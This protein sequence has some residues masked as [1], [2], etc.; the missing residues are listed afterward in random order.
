M[1]GGGGAPEVSLACRFDRALTAL[2]RRLA[3]AAARSGTGLTPVQLF[4]LRSLREP[5][6]VSVTS[7]AMSLGVGPSAVTLLLNR[8]EQMGLIA[9]RRDP[10]DRR[11]VRIRLTRPGRS[12]LARA[13]RRRTRLAQRY[14]SRL[15]PEQAASVVEA[16]E[17]MAGMELFRR[18]PAA[19][20]RA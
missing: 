16:L 6:P 10:A 7:L 2:C 17:R 18:R 19:G 5:E 1:T 9:R 4:V 14:L 15:S 20:E 8:L 13:E 11:V 12:T 3:K